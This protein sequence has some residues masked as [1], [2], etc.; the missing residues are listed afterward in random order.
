MAKSI[1][2]MPTA[3]QLEGAAVDTQQQMLADFY[4]S[5]VEEVII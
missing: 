2:G 5:S 4:G 1:E 3:K